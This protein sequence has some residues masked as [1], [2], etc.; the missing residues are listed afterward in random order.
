[1]IIQN[2]G[3]E[4]TALCRVSL[5]LFGTAV[6]EGDENVWNRSEEIKLNGKWGTV[7]ETMYETRWRM[8]AESKASIKEKE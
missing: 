3:A 8:C 5:N 1:M 7:I 6:P 4:T 2:Q